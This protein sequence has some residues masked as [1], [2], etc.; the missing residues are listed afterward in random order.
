MASVGADCEALAVACGGFVAS[1]VGT[2]A[3][4]GL[5][6]ECKPDAYWGQ[7]SVHMW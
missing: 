7:R 1:G 6:R 4:F 3:A 5:G 2:N